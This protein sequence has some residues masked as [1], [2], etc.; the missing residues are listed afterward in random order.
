[1]SFA[2][3]LGGMVT[4]KKRFLSKKRFFISG[5]HFSIDEEICVYGSDRGRPI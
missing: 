4:I 1:V 2:M 5:E 3:S